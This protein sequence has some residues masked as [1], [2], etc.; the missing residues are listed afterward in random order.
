M[1]RRY[2]ALKPVIGGASAS[3]S[4]VGRIMMSFGGIFCYGDGSRDGP[5]VLR[6]GM[7]PP[8]GLAKAS[9]AAGHRHANLDSAAK[10][11][12]ACQLNRR[13]ADRRWACSPTCAR[14]VP[15]AAGRRGT[16]A[17][18]AASG[19]DRRGRAESAGTRSIWASCAGSS[20]AVVILAAHDGWIMPPLSVG[21]HQRLAR[22][23]QTGQR[24]PVYTIRQ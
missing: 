17:A 24:S 8:G 6:S 12:A 4:P 19:R 14:R 15:T 13:R 3:A 18:G 5:V 16:A 9:I 11:S 20:A 7:M 21:H 22:D 10:R 23:A 1:R 2:D